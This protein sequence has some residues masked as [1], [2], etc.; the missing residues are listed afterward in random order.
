M[1]N[2]LSPYGYVRRNHHRGAGQH[3]HE[4]IVVVE[5]VLGRAL[6]VGAIVHHVNQVR[7]DNRNS[8]LCVLQSH[9]D[10]RELHR[11]AFKARGR[12]T[13]AEIA[14]D[15]ADLNVGD[16]KALVASYATRFKTDGLLTKED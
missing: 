11:K 12:A 9:T 13:V 6:P 10:H 8:N 1:S 3:V 14:A 2:S 16:V 4:H 5:T 15:C 7:S